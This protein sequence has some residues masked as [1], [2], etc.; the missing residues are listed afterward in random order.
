MR[1]SATALLL[2]GLLAL[3]TTNASRATEASVAP[4]GTAAETAVTAESGKQAAAQAAPE[5]DAQPPQTPTPLAPA[6]T[7]GTGTDNVTP[8]AGNAAGT[9]AVTGNTTPPQSTEQE[10]LSMLNSSVAPGTFRT[11]HWS[12]GQYI[13]SLD[14]PVPILVAHGRE[15][16]PSLCLTAAI[17]GDE[18]NG[19]EIVRR[20]LHQIE[21][22]SLKGTVIGVPIV[23]LD[24]FRRATRYLSDRR[25][26]N[27]FFPGSPIGSYASRM[28]HSL[29]Q[30]IILKCDYTVDIHTASFYRTNLPQLRG[31]L[32]NKAVLEFSRHFGGMSVLHNAGATGTLR[33]AANDAGIPSLTMEAGGPHA[34][35]QE[36]IAFGVKGLKNLMH[37]LNM[38]Q[39]VRLWRMPQPVFYQSIWVRAKLGGIML[40]KV[41]LDE[42]VRQGQLLGRVIDP[43]TNTSS[44]I[45]SPINGTILGKA[46]DQVVS[47]GFATFHIGV[48]ATEEQ[49]ETPLPA[50][51]PDLAPPTP[52]GAPTASPPIDPDAVEAFPDTES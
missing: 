39:T 26:L 14:T 9:D 16:G 44:D 30:Q 50:T 52:A 20:V 31:D 40:S 29:F 51:A 41:D 21:P 17:H 3:Q 18:I 2:A 47:P 11:L 5:P 8:P 46:L 35:E 32:K 28:A 43:I 6:T 38:Y 48:V 25:D 23:N 33:R 1:V 13:S 7:T 12:P 22:D 15:E 37:N 45:V 24:G 10:S 27:R 42:N 49:L 19:I 34:L 36:A 4:A